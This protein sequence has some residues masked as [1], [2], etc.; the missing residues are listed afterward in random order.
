M[1]QLIH[2]GTKITVHFGQATPDGDLIEVQ[3]FE[4]NLSRLDDPAFAEL[5]QAIAQKRVDLAMA[6]IPPVALTPAEEA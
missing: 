4:W 5:R 3:P 6:L 2:V 1:N